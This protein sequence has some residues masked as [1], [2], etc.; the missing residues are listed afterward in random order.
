MLRAAAFETRDNAN[1][2]DALLWSTG[3]EATGLCD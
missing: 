2:F 1:R 3:R